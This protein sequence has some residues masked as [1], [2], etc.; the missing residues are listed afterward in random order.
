MQRI[1]FFTYLFL[2]AAMLAAQSLPTGKFA[3]IA[4]HSG[5]ALSVNRGSTADGIKIVQ[6]PYHEGGNQHFT[7]VPK[8]GGYYQIKVEQGGKLL[9]APTGGGI[10]L[11]QNT[12]LNNDYQLFRFKPAANGYFHI[13]NKANG[14]YLDVTAASNNNGTQIVLWTLHGGANQLFKIQPVGGADEYRV[15]TGIANVT[16][17]ATGLGMVGFADGEQKTNGVDL[18]LY[19]RAFIIE[20]KAS[21]KRV[22]LMNA[23]LWAIPHAVKREVIKQLKR[24]Y[25][26][27]YDFDNCQLSATHTH[28]G[29]GGYGEYNLYNMTIGGFDQTNFN[30]I[31]MGIVK[32]ISKAHDN[33]GDGK[34]YYGSQT[35]TDCGRNRSLPAYNRNPASERN[36][37][38]SRTDNRL[39]LLKF[40]KSVQGADKV[41]GAISWYAIH[42]TDRG[43][44][45]TKVTGD[46]KGYAS[47]LVEKAN[48][49]NYSAKETFVAAFANAS[50][51]DV[52]GNVEYGQIPNGTDDQRHVVKHAKQQSD[53]VTSLLRSNLTPVTGG[54]DFRHQFWN[55]QK[56]TGSYGALGISFG[57]GSTED[58]D[59]GSGLKEGVST[60]TRSSGLGSAFDNFTRD[61]INLGFSP[62]G[63]LSSAD[64]TR[65]GRVQSPKPV[66]F[67]S[68]YA[69][70]GVSLTPNVLPFQLI[71]I[72]QVA[73]T[74]IPAEITTMA[75]RRLQRAVAAKLPSVDQVIL[76]GFAN[77]Y[78]QYVTTPEEYDA[79]HY[80]GAST[81]FGRTTLPEYLKIYQGLAS[82]MATGRSVA[83]E[84]GHQ[85]PNLLSGNAVVLLNRLTIR[86]LSSSTHTFDFYK[87]GDALM[88]VP[89]K[90]VKVPRNGEVG[91]ILGMLDPRSFKV[92]MDRRGNPVNLRSHQLLTVNERNQVSGTNFQA[93]N[94]ARYGQPTPVPSAA[95]APVPS[96]P[97]WQIS[98][99]I[100]TAWKPLAGSNV[101][102]A[103]AVFGDFNGDGKDDILA[104]FNGQLKVSYGCTSAWANLGRT[105]VMPKDMLIGD[106]DNDGKSDVIHRHGGKI[107]Y[108]SGGKGSWIPLL[109][110]VITQDLLRIGDF[111]GDGKDDILA[112]FNGRLRISDNGRTT[113]QLKVGTNIG[114]SAMRA[115]DFNGDGKADILTVFGG[116]FQIS[117]G[118]GT[119]WQKK[120][121][122]NIPLSSM[123]FADVDGDGATDVITKFGGKIQV[124][125]RASGAWKPMVGTSHPLS[126]LAFA[127]VDGIRGADMITNF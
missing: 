42:P 11:Y 32:A 124:C 80:E 46:N 21:R 28:S 125:Y 18:N 122:T 97:R 36:Q 89:F 91:A 121:G 84:S 112:I 101:N 73:I 67:Y 22:V 71:R 38:R 52:S 127:N 111:T 93:R 82:A 62:V 24:K 35:I 7:L 88:L 68:G 20:E 47:Y 99:G 103:D 13:V 48:G 37:Y 76:G 119:G 33:L 3:L 74:S 1:L 117:Y 100:K 43:Q 95:P 75:G 8:A 50:A 90:T 57:A 56:R 59:P 16:D 66:L 118:A 115:G 108:L 78:S 109:T 113:W 44:A 69:S 30:I 9:T 10:D 5:Q 72:G 81:L 27:L 49:T 60:A 123:R 53:A 86:N 25:G 107:H 6:W 19:A 110:T 29:P 26:S 98:S 106:M 104:N 40:V 14:R 45:N 83:T 17:P 12:S 77:H 85:P 64:K 116:H 114:A 51:G 54:L 94:V 105:S 70:N 79:Q 34:I 96:G 120:T 31:V 55:M 126:R 39:Y 61:M 2:S 63:E 58:S 87:T 92:R 41:V 102:P 23:D 65:M 15:G 4:K